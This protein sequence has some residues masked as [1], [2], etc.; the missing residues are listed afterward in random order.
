M[1]LLNCN[2]YLLVLRRGRASEQALGAPWDH[3]E[4]VNS[5]IVVMLQDHPIIGHHCVGARGATGHTHDRA[6]GRVY[7]SVGG[8]DGEPHTS[9]DRQHG[10][11]RDHHP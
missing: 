11:A 10:K 5:E 9:A 6:P 7:R 4:L 1:N 8:G 2:A 3:V